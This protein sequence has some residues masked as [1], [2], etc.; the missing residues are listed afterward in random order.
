[1]LATNKHTN[2]TENLRENMPMEQIQVA[3]TLWSEK[4]RLDPK[5]KPEYYSDSSGES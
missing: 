5:F 3:M 1:M 2:P 4:N